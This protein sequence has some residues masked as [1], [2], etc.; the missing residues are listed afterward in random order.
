MSVF[1]RSQTSSVERLVANGA[2][3]ADF[4]EQ[5]VA[6]YASRVA[7]AYEGISMTYLNVDHGTAKSI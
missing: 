5:S 7:L 6:A 2:T 1:F 3:Y 4:W